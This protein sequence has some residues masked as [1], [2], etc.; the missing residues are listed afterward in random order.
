MGEVTLPWFPGLSS[1]Q[2]LLPDIFHADMINTTMNQPVKC[3]VH[4]FQTFHAHF[5]FM[6]YTEVTRATDSTVVLAV[7]I[8]KQIT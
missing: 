2:P 6:H 5:L 7:M 3:A 4:G 8:M 1:H